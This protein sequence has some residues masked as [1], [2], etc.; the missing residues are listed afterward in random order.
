MSA[1]VQSKPL[2]RGHAIPSLALGVFQS[3]AGPETYDA[4]LT[5]LK[6]GCRHIDTATG[7]ESEGDVGRAIRD[8]GIP[9]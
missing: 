4:V 2:P 3:T 1:L 7:Y 9:R 6:L 5:A 8:S